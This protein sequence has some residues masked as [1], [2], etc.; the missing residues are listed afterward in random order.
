MVSLKSIAS[1]PA[2]LQES[3]AVDINI[4]FIYFFCIKYGTESLFNTVKNRGFSL[5]ERR[6]ES[7]NCSSLA[8]APQPFGQIHFT[9]WQIYFTFGKIYLKFRQ[10]Q[11]Q[12]GHWCT[13][14]CHLPWQM[15][16]LS[17]CPATVSCVRILSVCP[18][19]QNQ[20]APEG[21]SL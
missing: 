15:F 10:I 1:T 13:E 3:M 21:L 4:A 19:S 18:A 16:V 9:I 6:N 12:C 2:Q 14:C 11:F 7:T 20:Y 17:P 8:M 5:E